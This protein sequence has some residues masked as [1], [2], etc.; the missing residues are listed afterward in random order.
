MAARAER[1]RFCYKDP[2]TPPPLLKSLK[3]MKIGQFEAFYRKILSLFLSKF[4]P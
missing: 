2:Q 4:S 1:S 3:K